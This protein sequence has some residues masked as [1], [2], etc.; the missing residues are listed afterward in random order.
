MDKNTGNNKNFDPEGK[1]KETNVFEESGKPEAKNRFEEVDETENKEVSATASRAGDKKKDKAAKSGNGSAGKGSA[2]EGIDKK[3]SDYSSYVGL[4]AFL[5]CFL[6]VVS[7]V[8]KVTPGEARH[9]TSMVF[10]LIIM[11]GMLV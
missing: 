6:C 11:A 8:L 5:F 1:K 2:V 4:L 9:W 10:V 7:A 3:K